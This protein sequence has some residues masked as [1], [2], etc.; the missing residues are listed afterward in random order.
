MHLRFASG[1]EVSADILVGADG[2]H[3]RVRQALFGDTLPIYTGCMAWRGLVPAG[4]LPPRLLARV[5]TN[6]I[7]PGAH[8]ITYPVRRGELL[9][10]VG[11]VERDDWKGESWTDAGTKEECA[12]DFARLA[13]RCA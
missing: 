13:R 11:I 8:V 7:G 5:G 2:V 9:N 12:A 3:S 10:F 1:R 4:R 6:R